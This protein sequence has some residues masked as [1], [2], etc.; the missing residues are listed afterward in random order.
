MET[1]SSHGLFFFFCLPPS[2]LRKTVSCYLLGCILFYLFIFLGGLTRE[3]GE[4]KKPGLAGFALTDFPFFF[5]PFVP[6]LALRADDG[7]V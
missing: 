3:R 6:L 4:K 2:S 1:V 7:L 5:P